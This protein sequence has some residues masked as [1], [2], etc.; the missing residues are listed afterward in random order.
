MG[1]IIEN[2][3][4]SSTYLKHSTSDVTDRVSP[5]ALLTI[6]PIFDRGKGRLI[7]FL[8]DVSERFLIPDLLNTDQ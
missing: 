1:A 8:N 7:Q 6:R 3:R 2:E 5:F 4:R